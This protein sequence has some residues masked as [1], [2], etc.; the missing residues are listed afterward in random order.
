M[1][2]MCTQCPN[3]PEEGI[4]STP[5]AAFREA[6]RPVTWVLGTE[7]QSS[8]R[9]LTDEPR[10]QPQHLL[11]P[12]SPDCNIITSDSGQIPDNRVYD[13]RTIELVNPSIVFLRS[14]LNRNLQGS[15]AH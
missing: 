15:R 1:C 11:A 10:L 7:P 5:R 3:K 12:P 8:S 4:L 14:F 2:T 6:V 13:K 9:D